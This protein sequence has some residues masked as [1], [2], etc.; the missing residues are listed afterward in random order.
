MGTI[1]NTHHSTFNFTYRKKSVFSM[2]FL[3]ELI[4]MCLY[5]IDLCQWVPDVVLKSE[6][7]NDIC[8]VVRSVYGQPS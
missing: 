4:D 3:K 1:F 7:F 5:R 6:R 2:D 8:V